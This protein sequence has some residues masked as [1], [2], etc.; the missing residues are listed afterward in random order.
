MWV[1]RRCELILES[2]IKMIENDSTNRLTRNESIGKN[3][4]KKRPYRECT[5]VAK[6]LTLIYSA[7]KVLVPRVHSTPSE[8]HFCLEHAVS[9]VWHFLVAVRYL[10]SMPLL[11]G[12]KLV[13]LSWRD[14]PEF[15][16]FQNV[17]EVVGMYLETI[18]YRNPKFL[19]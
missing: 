17:L 4:A 15:Y 3:A 8:V 6:R 18:F 16:A 9:A 1:K 2:G 7:C 5:E 10:I 11:I 19:I 14:F 12:S 13:E